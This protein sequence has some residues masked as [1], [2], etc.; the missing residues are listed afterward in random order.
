MTG[1]HTR[2]VLTELG[3]DAA[4]VESLLA[5]GVIEQYKGENP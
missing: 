2:A 5:E 3:Y 1:E 4:A